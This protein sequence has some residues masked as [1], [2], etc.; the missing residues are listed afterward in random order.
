LRTLSLLETVRFP[1]LQDG[2]AVALL[3]EMRFPRLINDLARDLRYGVRVLTRSPL[4]TIVAVCSL[5]LGI[6]GAASVFTV[7][8]AVVLRELPVSN[9]QQLF[10]LLKTGTA[11]RNPRFG[12]PQFEDA[13]KEL[14]G[15]AELTAFIST[16]TM[17]VRQGTGSTNGPTERA[18]VQ[19][20]S[21][22]FFQVLR[23]QPQAGRLL[24]PSD[25]VTLGGHPV[26]VIS[27]AYWD[28]QFRRAKDAVGRTI[29]VNG[30]AFTV[31]GITQPAFYGAI[32]STRNPEIWVPLMMQTEVRYASNAS[33]NDSADPRK[34]WPPQR[35]IEW[36]SVLA[37][38]PNSADLGAVAATLTGLYQR[39]AR[40]GTT[41]A[42]ADTLRRIQAT[43]VVL[44]PAGRGIS[45]FRK[46]LQ[47]PLRVLL[48]MVG[49]LLAIACGNVASLLI[50]RA[51]ARDRE[52]AI[53]L[54]IGA[55]RG[56]V[57]RQLLA[58]ALLLATVGG[59]LG[60]LIAAWGRDLLLGMFARGATVIDLDTSFD[61]RVLAFSV[62][63]TL[64]TGIVAG[65]GP[66]LRGTRV[67][68]AES[69]KS[70]GRTV[71]AEGG[72]RGVLIGKT[73]VAAQIAFCLLLL[74]LA[75][76]FT[77]SMQS[78]LKIDVGFDRE[79]I[80]VARMDVR[81]T[82]Y[83]AAERQALYERILGKL[84]AVPGV[85]SAS[86]SLNGP[87]GTSQRTSSLSVEGYTPGRD[88]NLLTNEEV[89][90]EQYFDTV[91]LEI[92]EGRSFGPEDRSP[93]ARTTVVNQTMARRFFPNGSAVGRRW[94][95][96]DDI[97]PDSPRIV[98][99]VKDAKYVDVRGAAPN[100]IYRLSAG[101]P[102]DV[103]SNSEVRT[104]TP[105]P[106]LATTIKRVLAEA[107]PGL[108]VFDIIPLDERL[109]R[110]LSTDRLVANL[111][112]AFGAVALLLACLGLYG[113]I[114]YGVTRRVTELGVRMALGAARTSVLWLVIRE[115]SVLV[116]IG[117]A[118]GVP[119][120]YAAGR[121]VAALLY[122]V[123]PLDAM[124]YLTAAG[125]LVV[126]GGV[127]AFLP[128]HR[129]S[130]IDPMV[131]LRKQ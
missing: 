1:A 94:D 105:A 72:R 32:V 62:G 21:G 75:A 45:S 41:P 59:G 85:T 15:K 34:P 100:M 4:F 124:A 66:A 54:S 51:N 93:A 87:L 112:V 27:D 104:S 49:V 20:V 84:S 71:G 92:V 80:L 57:I 22:E 39:D 111:T 36:L 68:L 2:P 44:E 42:D 28:K 58:E 95:Y 18:M 52:M 50:S 46:D 47:S 102:D 70:Q 109:N 117:A 103:L 25:N 30:S 67:S 90:T 23:Q 126:V 40:T 115:A 65:I 73:L 12:W 128:A 99:V 10:E 110:G 35:G 96:G 19:L 108:P 118:I 116:L 64:M 43:Q 9:P 29:L 113:T 56:R 61:W 106:K 33:N 8:N 37:R 3:H 129:A 127:A 83:S 130:R 125:L 16:T 7:L 101:W 78:L 11:Q 120:A 53:R 88:E 81:S 76:L 91:G 114:S 38:V 89:I 48:G 69:L 119:L 31:V 14:H 13:R 98:G 74:V 63:I 24:A 86:L 79:Q 131:A 17:N 60:L 122:G 97:T 26:A 121:S 123:R 107:E 55:G 6:G 77:R 5:A 82:G